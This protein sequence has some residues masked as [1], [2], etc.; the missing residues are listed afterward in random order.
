MLEGGW[1]EGDLMVVVVVG[2]FCG[3]R[4]VCPLTSRL[5]VVVVEV[6]T[7]NPEQEEVVERSRSWRSRTT[8]HWLTTPRPSTILFLLLLLL[9]LL[10]WGMETVMSPSSLVAD[11]TPPATAIFCRLVVVVVVVVVVES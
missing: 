1:G 2:R 7:E 11:A 6:G 8:E 9:L 4:E 3:G 10:L 5:V